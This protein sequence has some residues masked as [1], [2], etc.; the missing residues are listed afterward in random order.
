MLYAYNQNILS[1]TTFLFPKPDFSKG[2]SLFLLAL[3]IFFG[4]MLMTHGLY[5][6][7]NYAEFNLTFADP[8]GMGQQLTLLFVIFGELC[9]SITFII[10]FLY[11]LCMIPMIIVMGGAF[12]YAH[13]GNIAEGELAF[14]YLIT[15]VLMYIAGPGK[16][17]VDAAI[18]NH[19]R[20]KEDSYDY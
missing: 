9:C 1:M 18:Y 6:L 16:Y 8:I 11:R 5:K 2:H 17:S 10:G 3:R 4:I 13:G 7:A 19:F 14:V 20:K 15:L 12:F